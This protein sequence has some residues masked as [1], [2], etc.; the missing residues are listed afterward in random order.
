MQIRWTD[1]A[2]RD[3]TNICDYIEAHGSADI[4]H[5]VAVSVPTQIDVLMQFP[6]HGRTGPQARHART[7]FSGLP[8]LCI[9]RVH[10]E[11]IEIVRIL[12]GAQIWL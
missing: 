5:R 6:E 4:A 11:A 3:L 1:S 12:H 8:Y 7:I 9:C 10:Q 2:V